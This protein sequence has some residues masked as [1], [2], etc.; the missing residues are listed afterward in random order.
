MQVERVKKFAREDIE[1][2]RIAIKLI[3][4]DEFYN[5]KKELNRQALKTKII[6]MSPSILLISVCYSEILDLR[7]VLEMEGIFPSLKLQGDLRLATNGKQLELDPVQTK[8]L[9]TVA[10]NIQKVTIMTGPEGS[11]K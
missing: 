11:G 8:L 3:N 4:L 10:R 6:S 7:F 9:Y 2:R 1:K 5:G